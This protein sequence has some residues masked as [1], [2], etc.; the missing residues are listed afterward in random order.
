MGVSVLIPFYNHI[1]FVEQAIQSV[2]CQS[3]DDWEI[4]IGINGHKKDSEMENQLRFIVSKFKSFTD[5]IQVLYFDFKSAQKALNWLVK[6][7]RNP[8]VAFLDADDY[9]DHTKL[10]KQVCLMDSYDIVGTQC[11]YVGD[12]K[13]SPHIPVWD[14]SGF[15]IFLGNP[16]LHSS[17]LMKKEL[18]EFDEDEII[19]DYDLWFRLYFK[20][21]KV[22]NVPDRLT[23]HRVHQASCFNNKNCEPSVGAKL[24]MKWM[25]YL[26]AIEQ[27][28]AIQKEY[29]M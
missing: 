4:L 25:K 28:Q 19:Y 5:K 24:K 2:I 29:R 26:Q 17:I 11:N 27:L 15:N 20:G 22:F 13:G 1:E 14:I 23:Y 12:M 3:Y 7:S 21:C 16:L 9:W 6:F 10:E 18:V 8:Y